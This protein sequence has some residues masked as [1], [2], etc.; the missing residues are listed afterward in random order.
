MRLTYKNSD[1]L[2]LWLTIKHLLIWLINP[3]M[4]ATLVTDLSRAQFALTALFHIVWPVTTPT[5]KL[6][7][8]NFAQK[9]AWR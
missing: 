3:F 1:R 4:S 9:R 8:N 5:P 2:G 7:T 6:S